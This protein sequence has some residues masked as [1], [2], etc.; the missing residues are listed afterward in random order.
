MG[1]L[2]SWI[3]VEVEFCQP[4]GLA[5]MMMYAQMVENREIVRRESNLPGYSGAKFPNHP[6]TIAK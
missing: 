5:E 4:V 3:K 1:G 6:H 2:L